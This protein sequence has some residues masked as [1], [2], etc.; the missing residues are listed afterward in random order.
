MSSQSGNLEKVA[1]RR[2]FLARMIVYRPW[3]VGIGVA[4]AIVTAAPM[5]AE[6][7]LGFD[8]ADRL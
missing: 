3:V 6:Y 5:P 1:S 8:H 2:S 7:G 4:C